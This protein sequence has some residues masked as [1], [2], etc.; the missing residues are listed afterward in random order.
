M[1]DAD[2]DARGQQTTQSRTT[3][4]PRDDRT[5]IVVPLYNEATVIADV[6][7]GL[8]ERFVHVVCVDDGSSDGSAEAAQRAGA[9]VVR[10]PV[11]LGQGAALQTG[12]DFALAHDDVE[13]IVTFDADGQHRVEDAVAMVQE[14]RREGLAIV[15]GSRF[16]DDRTDPG[17]VKKIILKTVVVVSNLTTGLRLSD[18]HNGL[19]VMRVD[20]ARKVDLQQDRMAHATE[21][22]LQLGRSGLPWKEF[23]VQL[24]YTD[25]SKAKGQSV[26]NAVN[27]LVDLV[28]R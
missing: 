8:L 21:I 17:L 9:Q 20:A 2:F 19:R 24:L 13:F 1:S 11:N 15:F 26:L 22:V 4:S 10:H 5:W 12:I 14:A 25:Y 28:V 7:T 3:I 16:L 23:P 18:A 6:V 27:I